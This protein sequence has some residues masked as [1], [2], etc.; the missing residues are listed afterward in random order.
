MIIVARPYG[1]EKNQKLSASSGRGGIAVQSEVLLNPRAV[2]A[3]NRVLV[4]ATAQGHE[5]FNVGRC[6]AGECA[7]GWAW[8]V[9]WVAAEE[10]KGES[11]GIQPPHL[12]DA[13]RPRH[14]QNAHFATDTAPRRA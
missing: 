8:R 2:L 3:D 5:R 6:K 10:M 9:V 11:R 1:N 4:S 14:N 13:E 7:A 12:G